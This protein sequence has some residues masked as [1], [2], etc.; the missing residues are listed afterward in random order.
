MRFGLDFDFTDIHSP[1]SSNPKNRLQERRRI[2]RK[3][4]D[5]LEAVLLQIVR[6][7]TGAIR[8]FAIGSPNQL[9]VCGEVVDCFCLSQS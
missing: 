1:R 5:T 7:A 4:P 2:R 9:F 3:D 8:R 6:Q